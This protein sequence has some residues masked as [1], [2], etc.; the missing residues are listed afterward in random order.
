MGKNSERY[1]IEIRC[2]KIQ[3]DFHPEITW[4]DNSKILIDDEV[5]T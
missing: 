4:P 3:D 1:D 2:M 5:I